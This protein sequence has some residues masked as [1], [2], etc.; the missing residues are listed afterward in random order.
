MSSNLEKPFYFKNY[1]TFLTLIDSC[2][3]TVLMKEHNI[4]HVFSKQQFTFLH[5]IFQ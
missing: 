4:P 2:E 3:L 1:N 5:K